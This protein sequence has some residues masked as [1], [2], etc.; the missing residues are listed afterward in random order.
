MSALSTYTAVQRHFQSRRMHGTMRE[1][2]L[3]RARVKYVL[4]SEF[5]E[6]PAAQESLLQSVTLYAGALE[7]SGTPQHD[8]IPS[9]VQLD[10]I[11][12]LAYALQSLGELVEEFGWANVDPGVVALPAL[13]IGALDTPA[14]FYEAA[15]RLFSLAAQGQLSVLST[16]GTGPSDVPTSSLPAN[17]PKQAPSSSS[18]A[19]TSSLV[20]P[21]SYLEMLAAQIS[22]IISLMAHAPVGLVDTV[23]QGGYDVFANADAYISSLQPGFG[24]SQ[25][26]DGE[27]DSQIKEL[28]WAS[29]ALR[30]AFVTRVSE[31][32]GVDASLD[33]LCAQVIRAGDELLDVAPPRESLTGVRL[34]GTEGSPAAKRVTEY[35]SA[36][37]RLS[38][39]ADHLHALARALLHRAAC[40]QCTASLQKAWDVCGYATKCRLAA[41][42][43]LEPAGKGASTARVSAA[44]KLALSGAQMAWVRVSSATRLPSATNP[45]TKVS[46]TRA[47]MYSELAALALTRCDALLVENFEPAANAQGKLLDNAR[48]YARRALVDHGLEWVPHVKAMPPHEPTEDHTLV[49]YG[50]ALAHAPAEG[51]WESLSNEADIFLGCVR[52]VYLRSMYQGDTSELSALAGAAWSLVRQGGAWLLALGPPGIQRWVDALGAEANDNERNFW[53]GAWAPLMAQSLITDSD[54]FTNLH[55]SWPV[56]T[57]A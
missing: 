22:C 19:Y 30:V 7:R 38:E 39:V 15:A 9:A 2:I 5:Y 16:M 31:L 44:Q 21:S 47:S 3:T 25:S 11:A 1:F 41:V 57:T 55:T 28:Q 35:E 54:L 53:L 36:V 43:P 13:D 17:E 24:A 48:I 33:D 20:A 29:I 27:W 23:Q 6:P 56:H 10:V 37:E 34:T 18:E 49:I 40:A 14:S 8:E 50:R 51:G 12:N 46:R 26:P 45:S 42:A 4:G 52:A 32:G